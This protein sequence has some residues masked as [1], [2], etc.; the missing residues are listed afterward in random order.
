MSEGKVF[1][2]PDSCLE[3]TTA[4]G[5]PPDSVTT[6]GLA[7]RVTELYW[8]Q[9]NPCAGLSGAAVL[10]QNSGGQ[11]PSARRMAGRCAST[12]TFSCPLRWVVPARAPPGCP[13]TATGS[14]AR[15][16][17]LSCR[18]STTTFSWLAHWTTGTSVPT[19]CVSPGPQPCSWRRRTK[20]GR[21]WRIPRDQKIAKDALDMLRLFRATPR[22]EL[23]R[24][25]R[26][27]RAGE[28]L[29]R[30]DDDEQDDRLLR[31]AVAGATAV[32][33]D[34]LRA[35]FSRE[36][37]RGAAIAGEAAR[38]RD[39]PAVIAASLAAYTAQLLA[40]LDEP[41]AGSSAAAR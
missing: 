41:P 1:A 38:G 32:G 35:E 40:A 20:W 39:D 22:D 14:R 24:V 21:G 4:A 5:A 31:V 16:P 12:S 30:A 27:A 13:I 33:I 25:L 29:R 18:S 3:G 23:A 7:R 9:T 6:A 37:A 2:L 34:I 19:G 8:P 11:A 36:S 15:L 10:R 17:A 26:A 28:L